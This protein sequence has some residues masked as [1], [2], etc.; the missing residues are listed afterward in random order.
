MDFIISSAKAFGNGEGQGWVQVHDY[1][2]SD[3]IKLSKRGRSFAVISGESVISEGEQEVDK[4]L[5]AREVLT[6][7]HEEYYGNTDKSAFTALKDAVNKISEELRLGD[8]DIEIAIAVFI[9][10]IVY[11]VVNGG[12]F[13]YLFRK[14]VLV[15]IIEGRDSIVSASGRPDTGDMLVVGSGDLRKNVSTTLLVEALAKKDLDDIAEAIIPSI[16]SLDDSSRSGAVFIQFNEKEDIEPVANSTEDHREDLAQ[17]SDQVLKPDQKQPLSKKTSI[18]ERLLSKLA[19]QSIR[20][21]GREVDEAVS[22]RRRTAV[23]VGSILLILLIVS[24]VFG[25]RTKQK[26]DRRALFEDTISEA[27]HFLDEAI[28]L[29]ELNPVRSRELFNQSKEKVAILLEKEITYPEVYDL[30]NKISENESKILG[31]YRIEP[32]LY[33]DLA[34]LSEG[35]SGSSLSSS[36]ELMLVLD[37]QNERLV[38]IEIRNK[39]TDIIAGDEELD[40]PKIAAIYVDRF[41]VLEKGKVYEVSLDEKEVVEEGFSDDDLISAF[42]GNIYVLTKKDSQIWRIAGSDEG[43]SDK[44]EWLSEGIEPDFLSATSMAIDGNIWVLNND[45]EILRFSLGNEINFDVEGLFPPLDSGV[46]IFTD[47]ESNYLYILEPEDKRIVVLDKEGEYVAQYISDSLGEGKSV[48]VSESERKAIV[49]TGGKLLL[50]ELKHL[51][52]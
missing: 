47:E 25:I 6:R 30:Q 34:L 43:F 14:G 51:G 26:R 5:M 42:A 48:I 27:E 15:K 19:S 29:Y 9:N 40:S 12:S 33:L 4:V 3:E 10:G 36:D 17:A 16:R 35:F 49:L 37:G 18:V 21:K 28:D 8:L 39:S 7:I 22:K 24:I 20:I 23:S 50:I 11:C 38:S 52:D 41:F 31:E 44:S 45:G 32:E 46:S 2:P 13:V 1:T